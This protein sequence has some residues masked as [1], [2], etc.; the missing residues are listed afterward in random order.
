MTEF[1]KRDRPD[2]FQ[3]AYTRVRNV[4]FVGSRK[5]VNREGGNFPLYVRETGP[6]VYLSTWMID[7]L[8]CREF[9]EKVK[10]RGNEYVLSLVVDTNVPGHPSVSLQI[11]EI[12]V[13]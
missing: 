5:L 12:K 4:E 9:I 13:D 6:G 11:Q 10:A 2:G 8:Y 1:D 3:Q 7:T